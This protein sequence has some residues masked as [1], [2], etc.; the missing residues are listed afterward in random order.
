MERYTLAEA[1]RITGVPA[2]AIRELAHAYATAPRAMLC[3]TLGITEHHNA[4]DNVLS[5][6]NLAL[7]TGKVGKYACGLNPLRGQNNVQ[8]GGDMGALPDRLPG[9]Q[10]VEVDAFR[11]KFERAWGAKIPPQRGWNLTQMFE[12]MGRKELRALMFQLYEPWKK[13]P[14]A[15]VLADV[16]SMAL[17]TGRTVPDELARNHSSFVPLTDDILPAGFMEGSE[18]ARAEELLGPD[19]QVEVL[20]GMGSGDDLS[21]I[22]GGGLESGF[23][24]QAPAVSEAPEAPPL[25]RITVQELADPAAAARIPSSA[26]DLEAAWGES[27]ITTTPTIST[28][29]ACQASRRA[30][31]TASVSPISSASAGKIGRM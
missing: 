17:N 6:C 22:L 12:A 26:I 3:W 29:T 7:L 23:A 19:H 15:E 2:D 27:A 11:E 14:K 13:R 8:G 20:S 4:V 10:H 24:L 9:F 1:E 21:D 5:L 18:A 31:D 30:A 25:G 28:A 16:F